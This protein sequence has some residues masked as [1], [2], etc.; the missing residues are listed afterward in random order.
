M[1][2]ASKQPV[3]HKR[4]KVSGIYY[5]V[6]RSGRKVFEVRYTTSDGN[7]VWETCE[8]FEHAKARLAEVTGR[9]MTGHRVANVSVTVADLLPGW[10]A[11]RQVKPRSEES[12]E[13]HI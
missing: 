12:Q 13:R 10:R 7:R 1:A 9:K 3:R 4:T 5:S 6:G 2:I 11:W 8:S